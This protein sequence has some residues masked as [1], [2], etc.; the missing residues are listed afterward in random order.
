MFEFFLQSNARYETL[1]VWAQSSNSDDRKVGW[2]ALDSF[3]TAISGAFAS[4]QS[5][6]T[7]EKRSRI[8]FKYLM[9]V[10]T[11]ILRNDKSTSQECTIAVQGYSHLSSAAKRHM[12]RQDVA[13]MLSQL[14]FK[15]EEVFLVND[16][17]AAYSAG[18]LPQ[19]SHTD[20]LVHL[21][22]YVEG[23]ANAMNPMD[24]PISHSILILLQQILVHLI[25]KFPYLPKQYKP[26]GWRS[27]LHFCSVMIEKE[28]QGIFK[29]VGKFLSEVLYQGLLQTCSHPLVTENDEGILKIGETVI[30][31]SSYSEFWKP[32][33]R[34]VNSASSS[35]IFDYVVECMLKVIERLNFATE[36]IEI[37]SANHPEESV[38]ANITPISDSLSNGGGSGGVVAAGEVTKVLVPKVIKD[39]TVLANLVKICD[40]CL[41]RCPSAWFEKWVSYFALTVM[42]KSTQSPEISG[43]YK[44]F[45]MCL[46]ICDSLNYFCDSEVDNKKQNAEIPGEGKDSDT[47]KL[48]D[49]YLGRKSNT[50][51][52]SKEKNL[53]IRYL[54]EILERCLQFS[55]HDLLKSSLE[56]VVA[57]P[58]SFVPDLLP[59]LSQPFQRIFEVGQ[60]YL[61]LAEKGVDTLSL[62]HEK[63]EHNCHLENFLVA[64]VPKMKDFMNESR[65]ELLDGSFDDSQNIIEKKRRN[66]G[67]ISIDSTRFSEGTTDYERVQEKVLLFFGSLATELHYLILPNDHELAELATSWDLE[68]QLKFSGIKFMNIIG[69]PS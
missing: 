43:L 26:K 39:F 22:S 13:L 11:K 33:L 54:E 56:L 36:T 38:L 51:H 2:R 45:S 64:V 27:F 62:W 10:F 28:N 40:Q 41:F 20:I 63:L 5:G 18:K 7:A 21:P 15:T 12:K 16:Q 25:K 69:L 57:L 44:L 32:I 53:F 61:S 24:E 65:R 67:K 58:L 47:M 60:N 4:V 14:A 59:N 30:S 46:R 68:N 49:E 3:L 50:E 42:R 55:N 48:H 9:D 52:K 37:S 17:F 66:T 31:V 8:T 35:V 23:M 6:S 29:D 1:C 34:S 19:Q